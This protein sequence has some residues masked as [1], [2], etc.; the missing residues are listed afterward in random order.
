MG[1]KSSKLW[2][3]GRS[4]RAKYA[5]D[6]QLQHVV[7]PHCLLKPALAQGLPSGGYRSHAPQASGHRRPAD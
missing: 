4:R 3:S 5:G 7:G 1:K 2:F 6:C